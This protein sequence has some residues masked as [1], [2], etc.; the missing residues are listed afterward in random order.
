MDRKKKIK[1]DRKKGVQPLMNNRNT[2]P[3]WGHLILAGLLFALEVA[4][5]PAKA[6]ELQSDSTQDIVRA[7]SKGSDS[8]IQSMESQNFEEQILETHISEAQAT[9]NWK[10]V[11]QE[12]NEKNEYVYDGDKTDDTM[13]DRVLPKISDGSWGYIVNGKVQDTAS[14]NAANLAGWWHVKNGWVDWSDGILYTADGWHKYVGGKK[15]LTANETV[16]NNAAGWF[17]LKDGTVD[18]SYTGLAQNENGVFWMNAGVFDTGMTGIVPDTIG[19]SA[20]GSGWFY[21]LGGIFDAT[22]D[23]I[24]AN[25]AGWWKIRDGL[26]D[27]TYNGLACNDTGWYYLENG[28]VDF[29]YYGAVQNEA[30]IW[31]VEHG[32]V[33]MEYNGSAYG[34]Y[35]SNGKAQ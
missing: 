15:E 34:Y 22:A 5:F 11:S 9:V 12:I 21:L 6:Q 31:Y 27:F 26:V 32:R 20:D 33:N 35:F 25:E 14:V 24:A 1:K 8:A 7:L 30:G 28:M 19:V 16:E 13:S 4:A 18:F 23:T 2:K 17:Y 3:R 10:L 29:G